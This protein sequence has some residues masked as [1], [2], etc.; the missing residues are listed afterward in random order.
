MVKFYTLASGS[1][2]NCTFVSDGK[3]NILIDCG[4]NG[5]TAE[6]NI[7]KIG[8]NPQ[9]ISAILITHEHSDHICGAGIFSRRFNTPVYATKET[10]QAMF[11]S[12]CRIGKFAENNIKFIEKNTEFEIGSLGFYAFSTPHDSA[13]SVGYN[14]FAENAKRKLSVATD[15]GKVDKD[16]VERL[17]GSESILLESN[18]DVDMLINGGYPYWLKQRILGAK[19]H[20]S[21]ESCA[22]ISAC[23]AKNGT[24]R[25]VLGH[26]S[27]E[28]NSP[29]AAYD[30][31][32]NAIEQSGA[33]IGGDIFLDVAKRYEL[34]NLF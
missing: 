5:K 28:N 6:T 33:K 11:N 16:V 17:L 2:G 21:N 9:N 22:K 32:K 24:K 15:M 14:I 31:S 7:K 10:W 18:H 12:K 34:T 8:E 3:T 25:I 13:D 1:S 19:G 27:D 23:L 26:L 20:L 30:A 4:I 29:A